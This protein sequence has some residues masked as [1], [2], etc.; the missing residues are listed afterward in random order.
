[1]MFKGRS[2]SEAGLAR[3]YKLSGRTLGNTI[4][5]LHSHRTAPNLCVIN[6]VVLCQEA[7]LVIREAMLDITITCNRSYRSYVVFRPD[8]FDAIQATPPGSPTVAFQT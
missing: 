7:R 6:I 2:E 4:T 5:R 1:M 8:P 3:L